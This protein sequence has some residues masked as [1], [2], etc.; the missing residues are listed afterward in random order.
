V[1][2]I[3]TS[4]VRRSWS[5]LAAAPQEEEKEEEEEEEDDYFKY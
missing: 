1:C 3:E 4:R 2:D 5:D